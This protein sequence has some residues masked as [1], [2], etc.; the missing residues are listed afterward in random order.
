MTWET[1]IREPASI[2][3]LGGSVT[4][5][6]L[7]ARGPFSTQCT[8]RHNLYFKIGAPDRAHYTMGEAHFRT[9]ALVTIAR[10]SCGTASTSGEL[11]IIVLTLEI[12]S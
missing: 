9:V 8:N 1:N 10:E 6:S 4:T 5:I 11:F 3:I 12:G 2:S 7:G